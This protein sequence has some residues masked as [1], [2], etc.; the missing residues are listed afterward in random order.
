MLF[1]SIAYKDHNVVLATTDKDILWTV[2]WEATQRFDYD[3]RIRINNKRPDV[4]FVD[5]YKDFVVI[6]TDEEDERIPKDVT[7]EFWL[8]LTWKS[9]G[10]NRMRNERYGEINQIHEVWERKDN[11]EFVL[12][13]TNLDDE[14]RS[15]IFTMHFH[16]DAL[17][18]KSL[19]G[20]KPETNETII[21][22]DFVE[23]NDKQI[24]MNGD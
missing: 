5:Y 22:V 24:G 13:E 21:D 17:D 20:D 14:T 18:P 15:D 3:L 1:K 10:F 16:N 6:L 7:I 12:I 8:D 11:G 19:P 4:L 23:V 9:K 2:F